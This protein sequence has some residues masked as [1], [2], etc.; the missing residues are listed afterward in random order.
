MEY[1]LVS[2]KM[3]MVQGLEKNLENRLLAMR[4]ILWKRA[5]NIQKFFDSFVSFDHVCLLLSVLYAF[6]NDSQPMQILQISAA[7]LDYL[8]GKYLLSLQG[9]QTPW[10]HN[11]PVAYESLC[12]WLL[13]LLLF[14]H[15][16]QQFQPGSVSSFFRLLLF[17]HLARSGSLPQRPASGCLPTVVFSSKSSCRM[18]H[19]VFHT[20]IN[21]SHAFP[22]YQESMS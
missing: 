10:S 2:P 15:Y 9:T 6:W 17:L 18:L 1:T 11:P 7:L 12:V 5:C 8:S 21:P 14:R 4:L 20:L 22:W 16:A 19:L 13:L 3:S